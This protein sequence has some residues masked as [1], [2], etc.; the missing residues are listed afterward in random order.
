MAEAAQMKRT[1]WSMSRSALL[2]TSVAAVLLIGTPSRKAWTRSRGVSRPL[3]PR[4]STTNAAFCCESSSTRRT[5]STVLLG[6]QVK[7]ASGRFMMLRTVMSAT[8]SAAARSTAS[9][10]AAAAG[11]S[12]GSQRAG[13][14]RARTMSSDESTQQRGPPS[15]R[16]TTW[17]Q[18]QSPVRA[19]PTMRSA[20]SARLSDGQTT[21]LSIQA[22]G[23]RARPPSSQ[24]PRLPSGAVPSK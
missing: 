4:S 7:T 14:Q 10:P 8:V 11:S 13:R 2:L 23:A 17:W 24:A 3:P 19:L 21:S 20:T 12:P 9:P 22:P 18:A 5:S 15:S 6:E 1:S 16:T